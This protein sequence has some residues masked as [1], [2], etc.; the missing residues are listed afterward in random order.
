M[1]RGSISRKSSPSRQIRNSAS[2]RP[3]AVQKPAKR[4]PPSPMPLISLLIRLCRKPGASTPLARIRPRSR[5]GATTALSRAAI[6]SSATTPK[7][8]PSSVNPWAA[9]REINSWV[10]G[11][12]RVEGVAMLLSPQRCRLRLPRPYSSLNAYVQTH[13]AGADSRISRG[14][15]G[16]RLA[17]GASFAHAKSAD[18]VLGAARRQPACRGAG[19]SGCRHRA[20]RVATGVDGARAGTLGQDQGRQL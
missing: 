10:I 15:R 7:R 16:R 18:C 8:L 5:R 12:V 14:N 13:P 9:R 2:K 17:L 11:G 4:A 1:S 19:G 6:S 3:L 20:A